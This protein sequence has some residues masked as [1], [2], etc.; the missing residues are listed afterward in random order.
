MT[1]I[2]VD[3]HEA[4]EVEHEE[5]V[6][7]IHSILERMDLPIDE[8]WPEDP[9]MENLRKMR[10]PLRKVGIDIIDDASDG[11]LIYL[12][13]DL[14]AEWRQPW[15][16]IVEDPKER[17]VRYRF[18]YEMHLRSRCVFEEEQGDNSSLE[19]NDS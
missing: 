17:D 7:W 15:Y 11:V 13:D 6:K 16:K 12:N 19:E 18:Y 1:V 9:S 4:R 2:L 3:R 10:K 8:W 5:K 14:I